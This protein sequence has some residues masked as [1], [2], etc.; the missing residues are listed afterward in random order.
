MRDIEKG[1]VVSVKIPTNEV[2][3]R[4]VLEKTSMTMPIKIPR[5]MTI[6]SFKKGDIVAYVVF[7][8]QTGVVL[9]HLRE[10]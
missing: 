5:N 10:L 9:S 6:N 1:V 3:V 2:R 8:D 7:E 4:S